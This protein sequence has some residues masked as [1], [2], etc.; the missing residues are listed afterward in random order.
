MALLR[1]SHLTYKAILDG[2]ND[3][4]S[5]FRY[6]ALWRAAGRLTEA[7]GCVR[8]FQAVGVPQSRQ[9]GREIYFSNSPHAGV[10]LLSFFA[11]LLFS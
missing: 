9:G 2:R 7:R 10:T 3:A 8:I 4:L 1:A 5:V 11:R 6:V